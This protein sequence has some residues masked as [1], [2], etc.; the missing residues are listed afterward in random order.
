VT[1]ARVE[2]WMDPDPSHLPERL[3]GRL[4]N[5][6]EF[7]K[8]V[9]L[10]AAAVSATRRRRAP[11]QSVILVLSDDRVVDPDSL[12]HRLAEANDVD[13]T[14]ACAGLP[15]NLDALKRTAR[16]ARFLLA[17]AGMLSEDLRELAME[18]TP[19][20]IVTLLDGV[21]MG[22]PLPGDQFASC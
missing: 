10:P 18:Q 21:H 13:V 12:G 11:Q 17:P 14:I 7:D 5:A 22:P 16:T 2:E 19:G 6:V 9:A 8:V 4:S 15:S 20:D 1:H 3:N